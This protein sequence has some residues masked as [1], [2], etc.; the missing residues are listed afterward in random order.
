[1]SQKKGQYENFADS[2]F[3]FIFSFNKKDSPPR[4]RPN[5]PGVGGNEMANSLAA[6]AE[7]PAMY[8]SEQS[9][10]IINEP[11]D[12]IGVADISKAKLSD[13]GT[14]VKSGVTL[15][16]LSEFVTNPEGAIDGAF[17]K[18][19]GAKKGAKQLNRMR[20]LGGLIDLGVGATMSRSLGAPAINSLEMGTVLG[21][22][23]LGVDDRN[24]KAEETASRASALEAAR[25]SAL[26]YDTANKNAQIFTSVM[27]ASRHE[28]KGKDIRQLHQ[29]DKNKLIKKFQKKGLTD[30]DQIDK[31][32][33]KYGDRAGR[34]KS[35][36]GYDWNLGNLNSSLAKRKDRGTDFATNPD[37][38]RDSDNPADKLRALKHEELSAEIDL[39][40]D[41]DPRKRTLLGQRHHIE[42]WQQANSNSMR[43]SAAFG[44][45]HHAIGS[46]NEMVL[47]GGAGAALISG[48]FF[49]NKKNYFSPS[50]EKKVKLNGEEHEIMVSRNDGS[51]PG[52][53]L[54]GLY[55]L[56]PGS[57][58]K[59]L[60]VNG[61]GFAY[62]AYKNQE[63]IFRSIKG[64]ESIYQYVSANQG[65][66]SSLPF[67]DGV[68]FNNQN[69]L[70]GR[71][72]QGENYKELL[73]ILNTNRGSISDPELLKIF[74][75]LQGWNN[76][77]ENSSWLK[78]A[79][80]VKGI[81]KWL[82]APKRKL[83]QGFGYMATRIFGEKAK[84]Y[85]TAGAIS[86]RKISRG[87]AKKAVHA[88]AQAFGFAV[89]G[90]LANVL[91]YAGTEVIY[92]LG[93]KLL[94]PAVKV[95]ALFLWSMGMLLIFMLL[96]VIN[97]FDAIN[98]FSSLSASF[99]TAGNTAPIYCEECAR[100][101]R[102]SYGGSTTMEPGTH[103]TE[104]AP[105]YDACFDDFPHYGQ[106]DP[107]SIWY[108]VTYGSHSTI[109][110][111]GCGPTAAAMILA[112]LGVENDQGEPINPL[113]VANFALQN[114]HRVPS[115]TAATLFPD[116]ASYY[117]FRHDYINTAQAL[118]R[119]R[120]GQP[121]ILL[122]NSP[123]VHRWAGREGGHFVVL[124]GADN[125]KVHIC[126]PQIEPGTGNKART[127]PLSVFLNNQSRGAYVIY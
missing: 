118:E 103:G 115:G 28:L 89:S 61:E 38:W 108:G 46:L 22:E 116:I 37:K 96:G 121:V 26:D 90:G 95:L 99:D 82:N 120:N 11:L 112:N 65:Q 98:P 72:A 127:V 105:S 110:A 79:G 5:I 74:D 63:K 51:Y 93:E 29:T 60:F 77:I 59:T 3:N 9:L 15:K 49:D 34:Y 36:K 83:Q 48:D 62:R 75:Q 76:K 56:T 8:A 107:N 69:E 20:G 70:L 111:S 16:N 126:D 101:G 94:K 30:Q 25:E 57:I 4:P 84:E 45:A 23:R 40:P 17:A 24:M 114:G 44:E 2:I 10:E 41:T 106:N 97:M 53:A 122:G 78:M 102:T 18:A 92:F 100:A 58:G 35:Q 113:D 86:L 12:S 124:T 81:N 66:F 42:V 54:T 91:I 43:W 119:A 50:E 14:A 80:F 1:M 6:I 47:K 21:N 87:L 64:S 33:Q 73:N 125:E 7:N 117:G 68:D 67:L 31:L 85:M 123:P 109:N 27:E 88:L 13:D 39:L 55:Y 104:Y 32:L 19:E 71:F 52:S